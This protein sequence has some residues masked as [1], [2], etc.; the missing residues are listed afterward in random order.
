MLLRGAVRIPARASVLALALAAV[1]CASARAQQ[2]TSLSP[3]ALEAIIERGPS[4]LLVALARDTTVLIPALQLLDLAEVR[5]LGVLGRRVEAQLN[6]GTVRLVFDADSLLAVRSEERR[7]LTGEEVTFRAGELYLSRD[8]LSW[9]LGVEINIDFAEL[10]L[11]VSDAGSL[12]VVQRLA[13][14]RRRYVLT[15]P[16]GP[17]VPESELYSTHPLVHGYVLDWAISSSTREPVGDNSVSLGFGSSVLGGSLELLSSLRTFDCFRFGYLEP[18]SCTEGDTRWSWTMAW[19]WRSWLRQLRAGDVITG[20]PRPRSVKG[21]TVTNSPFL[22]PAQFGGEHLTGVL[23]PGWEVELYRGDELIGYTPA[24]S[25][26]RF[27]LSVPVN[28]GPNPLQ[29]VAFGPRGEVTRRARTFQIPFDRLPAGRF[30]YSAGG[31][32]C[33]SGCTHAA[34]LDLRYGLTRRITLQAGYDRF[35]RG[36]LPTPAGPPDTLPDLDHPYALASV[37]VTRSLGL[38]VEAV[39]NAFARGRLDLDPHSDFHL[40]VGHLRYDTTVTEPLVGSSRT[41]TQS[42]ASVFWRPSAL[43]GDVFLQ[44]SLFYSEGSGRSSSRQRVSVTARWLGTRLAASAGSSRDRL[45]AAQA[46]RRSEVTISADAVVRHPAPLR[47]IL[48]R[49]T[50]TFDCGGQLL[51]CAPA[52][53]RGSVGVGRQ[54]APAVRLDVSV[55]KER[56]QRAPV[57][58]VGLS[59]GL[60]GLRVSSRNTVS[61]VC[62]GPDAPDCPL[63]AEA[64]GLQL[65]EGSLLFDRNT[66]SIAVGNG[67]NLGRGGVAGLVFMDHDG[68]GVRDEDEEGLSDVLLRVGS[69]AVVTDSSGRFSVWDLVPFERSPVEVDTVALPNPLW[70]PEVARARVRPSPN[71]FL[72]VEVPIEAGGE[73]N[74]TVTL[75]SVPASGVRVLLTSVITGAVREVTTFS[76]GSFYA[77]GVRAGEWEATVDPA[78][79]ERLSARAPA[80]R[81]VVGRSGP[82]ARVSG[83]ELLAVRR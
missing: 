48:L 83:V 49:A 18:G 13:R 67:R 45:P 7:R 55:R 73:V 15:E 68:D 14:E 46:S 81:F 69:E 76:D 44:G 19:P 1:A 27:G 56:G 42:D 16:Q 60:S 8:V 80:V 10:T 37:A 20:G 39:A 5:V 47:S 70:L 63:E 25:S 66:G 43:G 34:N 71:G 28:Y 50:A 64:S 23:A 36:V 26:G 62:R 54:I 53:R 74:G 41:R 58:D 38:T 59:T 29:Y 78:L 72:F 3:L 4:R 79:L 9:A 51:S 61:F 33:T 12:P 17:G 2:D 24:D 22:R 35:W 52:A 30:E 57:L 40:D 77:L 65:F 6:P 75:D 32:E 31:G 21:V 82:E 11:R